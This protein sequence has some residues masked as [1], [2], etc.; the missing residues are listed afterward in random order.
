MVQ[1]WSNFRS[2][3]TIHCMLSLMVRLNLTLTSIILYSNIVIDID[4]CVIIIYIS[5]PHIALR[6][7][8][9]SYYHH[10]INTMACKQEKTNLHSIWIRMCM[11]VIEINHPLCLLL[12][13]SLATLW[14]KDIQ[15]PNSKIK[16]QKNLFKEKFSNPWNILASYI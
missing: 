8:H 14:N 4:S 2:K 3:A 9:Q 5:T 12:S 13:T 15:V 1:S 10:M 11:I 16:S 6:N 7:L